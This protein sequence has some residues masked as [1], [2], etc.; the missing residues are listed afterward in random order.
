MSYEVRAFAAHDRGVAMPGR[1]WWEES[2]GFP[3]YCI[4]GNRWCTQYGPP[5]YYKNR[6][7]K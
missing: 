1:S 5:K 2:E 6:R 7:S 4:G 3:E